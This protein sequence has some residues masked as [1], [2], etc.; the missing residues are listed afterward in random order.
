MD[1]S[2]HRY[3]VYEDFFC[4]TSRPTAIVTGTGEII[5][6]NP[7]LERLLGKA[8]TEVVGKTLPVSSPLKLSLV[9]Q[10]TGEYYLDDGI[11]PIQVAITSIPVGDDVYALEFERAS[12]DRRSTDAM[13][14]NFIADQVPSGIIYS[15]NSGVRL[16]YANQA[17]GEIFGVSPNK[18]IADRWLDYIS[19]S[20]RT[21][22]QDAIIA[23]L[24]GKH[25]SVYLHPT[26]QRTIELQMSPYRQNNGL[27]G[28]W[29]GVLNDIS[30][31]K[32]REL[33]LEFVATHDALTG[34]RNALAFRSLVEDK[35][36]NHEDFTLAFCDIN[37]FKAINDDLGHMFGDR[38]LTEVANRLRETSFDAF[39]YGGDEFI[40]VCNSECP[41]VEEQI[42]RL[43]QQ[44][45]KARGVEIL[46]GISI[47]VSSTEDAST[48]D[49]IMDLADHKMY[50]QKKVSKKESELTNNVV[51]GK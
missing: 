2:D 1:K 10:L 30:E 43:F 25:A 13:D 3:E 17:A 14:A 49:G 37:G 46:L 44:P 15:L 36:R 47:G 29:V 4:A 16:S 20:E 41:D 42:N 35:L 21:D 40:L 23:V 18:L 32:N 9:R 11:R 33:D 26:Q 19:A 45:L 27:C 28:A 51:A 48:I 5:S 24:E 8:E 6:L 50:K 39:R 31:M 12:H 34:L 22:V 38:V 7:A